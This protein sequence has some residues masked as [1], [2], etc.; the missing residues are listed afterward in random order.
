VGPSSI[1]RESFEVRLLLR[2]INL[3]L[4]KG[5]PT[6]GLPRGCRKTAVSG[7]KSPCSRYGD[8]GSRGWM[9]TRSLVDICK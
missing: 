3:G 4:E 2:R 5:V 8:I 6:T 9:A 7:E 1:V